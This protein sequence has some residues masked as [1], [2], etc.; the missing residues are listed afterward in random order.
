MVYIKIISLCII[1]AGVET[2]HG[3]TRTI[4]IAPK[5]GNKQAK[6]YS[7]ISGTVLAFVVCY[8]FVPELDIDVDHQLILL[9]LTLS[10]FMAIFDIILAKFVVKQKW[11]K[12]MS[13][14]NPA[15]GNFLLFGLVALV[16]IPYV[17]MK[18]KGLI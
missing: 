15:E 5:I 14:F 4:F 18:L 17:V 9:G 13:D 10:G 12:V 7:V 1:L 3:I 8:I 6:Q 16:M 11:Q 2:L